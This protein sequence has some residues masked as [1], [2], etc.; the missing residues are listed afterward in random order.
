MITYILHGTQWE[1]E[2][3]SQSARFVARRA[4]AFR[5]ETRTQDY[6]HAVSPPCL[7]TISSLPVNREDAPQL[8]KSSFGVRRALYV[9]REGG[10]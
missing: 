2:V 3:L 8:I 4:R 9:F 7:K 6:G 1:R 10:L 5:Q